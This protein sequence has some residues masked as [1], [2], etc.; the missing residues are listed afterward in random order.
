MPRPPETVNTTDARAKKNAERRLQRREERRGLAYL[1]VLDTIEGRI[2]FWDLILAAGVFQ[3][4]APL[5]AEIHQLAGRRR[6]GLDLMKRLQSLD[7][8]RFQLMEREWWAQ[9]KRDASETEAAHISEADAAKD[10]VD[11]S[12]DRTE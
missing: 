12:Q 5:S 1:K 3:E 4:E 7:P 6:F 2:V 8:E 9:E 10:R 11:F